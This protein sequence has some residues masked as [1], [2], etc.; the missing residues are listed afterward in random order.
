M[1]PSGGLP[2]LAGAPAHV[3]H[4]L[5]PGVM[6]AIARRAPQPP[7]L[8]TTWAHSVS[9]LGLPGCGSWRVLSLLKPVW[10]G[11]WS[12]AADNVSTD[13]QANDWLWDILQIEELNQSENES[14]KGQ[15]SAE[16]QERGRALPD[17][18]R[19]AGGSNHTHT[20]LQNTQMPCPRDP[21][22]ALAQEIS[23][24]GHPLSWVTPFRP[25]R[26]ASLHHSD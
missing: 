3:P 18:C 7:P 20:Q 15:S 11:L 1:L 19:T 6:G 25:H 12:L 17:L 24:P 16:L 22:S 13:T 14:F 9:A 26:N 21:C 2:S 10:T 5:T 4:P 23:N 8:K